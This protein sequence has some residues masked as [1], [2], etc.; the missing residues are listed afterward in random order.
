MKTILTTTALILVLAASATAGETLPAQA[1]RIW[2][3]TGDL[4]GTDNHATGTVLLSD[5]LGDEAK[6]AED[7]GTREDWMGYGLF[8][9]HRVSDAG[10]LLS[11]RGA[12][13]TD[14]GDGVTGDLAV[15]S[16]TPGT[17]TA[18]L[19]YSKHNLY[20]D[21]DSEMRNPAFPGGAEPSAL[22]EIP[23]L[24][25]RRGL[26][27]LRYHVA[28][29]L[30]IHG[31]MKDMRREG[32]KASLLRGWGAPNLP[33]AVQTMDTKQ[34]EIFVGGDFRRGAFSSGLDLALR[35]A[36]GA[37]EYSTGRTYDD[38]RKTYRADLDVAYD[39]AAGTRVSAYGGM[40]RLELTGNETWGAAGAGATDSDA[41]SKVGQLALVTR[42]GAAT[43]VS[44]SARFENLQ[45][46]S[47]IGDDGGVLYASDRERDRQDYRLTIVNSSLP[48][49][50]VRLQYRYTDA[51]MTSATGEGG[52]AGETTATDE[53]G[54]AENS[55]RQD[56]TLR[57]RTMLGRNLKLKGELR[58]TD[59]DV[60]QDRTGDWYGYFG[61]HQRIT[62]GW[63]VA[64]STRLMPN[65]PVDLGWQGVDQN[66]ERTEGEFAETTWTSNRL[67][68]NANW[69][70]SPRLS[71]YALAS[72]GR[73]EY[74][75]GNGVGALAGHAAYEYDGET[76]RLVPGALFQ[77]TSTVQLEGMYELI[78]YENTGNESDSLNPVKADHDRA[79]V[80]VRWQT[81]PK[82]AVTATY[83]R[84][85]FDENR[86]DD[87]IQ[88]LYAVS[89]SGVF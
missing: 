44:A 58:Y 42:F 27:A 29:G 84:N 26:F 39:A 10:H 9:W 43:T 72:Y 33:P 17:Y 22:P 16:S 56:A 30:D 40:S 38:E 70:V 55:K 89:V 4:I 61:D 65:L 24:D 78:A 82:Y 25:W 37:R 6:L 19:G 76:T 11:V 7:W 18:S 75:L 83:K 14:E 5:H 49:T 80:R 73:E 1:Q 60:T 8:G 32:D 34:Y 74:Q 23:Q 46:E 52:R 50:R 67:Y 62:F 54:L 53:Q 31:G 13:G 35:A 3:P 28:D 36:D 63:K 64:L 79:M 71:F 45:N 51:D 77:L 68:A 41:T 21:T 88:D 15:T 87:Y 57:A 20:Y 59:L 2:A 86:W 81:T 69:I 85:E 48:R 47:L 12:A 66:L